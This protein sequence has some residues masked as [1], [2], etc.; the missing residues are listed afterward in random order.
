MIRVPKAQLYT[1]QQCLKAF[2]SRFVLKTHVKAHAK[3]KES[4]G[5]NIDKYYLYYLYSTN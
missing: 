5:G 4:K 3:M 2:H 1:C